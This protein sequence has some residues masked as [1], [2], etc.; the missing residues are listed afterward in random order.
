[1]RR[2]VLRAVE[3]AEEA[4]EAAA[5]RQARVVVVPEVPLRARG[6]NKA[7]EFCV[8]STYASGIALGRWQPARNREVARRLHSAFERLRKSRA[9]AAHIRHVRSHTRVAGN[10]VADH[11]AKLA[12]DTALRGDGVPVLRAAK[13]EYSRLTDAHHG[14]THDNDLAPDSAKRKPSDSTT[15]SANFSPPVVVHSLGVG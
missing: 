4:L 14:V 2:V 5:R 10:E 15:S 8:D 11:L 1:M 3:H 13:D 6:G 12:R 7:V 9:G